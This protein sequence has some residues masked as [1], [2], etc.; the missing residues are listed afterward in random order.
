MDTNRTNERNEDAASCKC[1]SAP[2]NHLPGANQ[3]FKRLLKALED[4]SEN[5][6]GGPTEATK[7]FAAALKDAEKTYQSMAGTV[8]KYAEFYNNLD[9][10]LVQVKDWQK[11]LTECGEK[12]SAETRAAIVDLRSTAY[13][14]KEKANCCNWVSLRDQ[15]ISIS[16][17]R[18]QARKKEEEAK[19]DFDALE[20]LESALSERFAALESLFK[21][22]AG[23]VKSK[24]SNRFVPLISNSKQST[25]VWLSSTPGPIAVRRA[26]A[27]PQLRSP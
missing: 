15:L 11:R 2:T 6:P 7:A 23:F 12:V 27:R 3:P 13:D 20:K 10:K 17:C 25:T 1:K 16:D 21:Q 8:A 5:V 4:E 18:V 14:A 24:N 19:D 22:A 9:C 26:A